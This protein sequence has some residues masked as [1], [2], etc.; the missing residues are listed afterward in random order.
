[1][2]DVYTSIKF[3][4]KN[5]FQENEL[6]SRNNFEDDDLTL[7]L[8]PTKPTKHQVRVGVFYLFA[9]QH[10]GRGKKKYISIFFNYK[11]KKTFFFIKLKN[12]R[13]KAK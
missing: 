4:V 3:E 6:A 5:L 11:E 1:M 13:N 8:P 7:P 12:G 2:T 9:S 10:E